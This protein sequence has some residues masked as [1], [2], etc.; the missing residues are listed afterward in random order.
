MRL[1]YLG[2]NIYLKRRRHPHAHDVILQ[3]QNYHYHQC[4]ALPA[5]YTVLVTHFAYFSTTK[6]EATNPQRRLTFIELHDIVSHKTELFMTTAIRTSN[7][8]LSV[9]DLSLL[10]R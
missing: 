4:Q 2:Q 9:L 3:E 10:R 5:V 6:M 7:P 1:P 8:T